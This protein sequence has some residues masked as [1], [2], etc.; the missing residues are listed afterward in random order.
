MC[1]SPQTQWYANSK[2]KQGRNQ[3]YVDSVIQGR[4]LYF[5]VTIER[6]NKDHLECFLYV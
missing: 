2:A 6:I 5:S 3:I 4:T 1:F